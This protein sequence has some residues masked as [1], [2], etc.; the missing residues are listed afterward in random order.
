MV[1]FAEGF[2]DKLQVP[3]GAKDVQDFDSASNRSPFLKG[4][5]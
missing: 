1:K 3:A 5:E 4:S 2:A